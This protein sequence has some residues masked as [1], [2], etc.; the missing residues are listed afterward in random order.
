MAVP[1]A[2]ASYTSTPRPTTNVIPR[3]PNH[4]SVWR[5]REGAGTAVA[6]STASYTQPRGWE[7]RHICAS[8]Q[9][10]IQLDPYAFQT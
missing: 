6:H 5:Q 2:A 3:G 10:I 8:H 1:H 9:S 4:N 7:S